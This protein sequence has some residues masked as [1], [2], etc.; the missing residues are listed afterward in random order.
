[1]VSLHTD[2]RQHRPWGNVVM[3]VSTN[4]PNLAI[5]EPGAPGAERG[6]AQ[7]ARPGFCAGVRHAE[8]VVAIVDENT[9]AC[10]R[11]ASE[12][13]CRACQGTLVLDKLYD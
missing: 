4:G 10:A 2:A 13:L 7:A 8:V 9:H 6:Q 3:Q 12:T 1:M 11:R 5:H